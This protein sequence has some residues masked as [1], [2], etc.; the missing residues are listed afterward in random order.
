MRRRVPRSIA[1]AAGAAIVLVA[2]GGCGKSAS[3]THAQAPRPA[4]TV[5]VATVR[6]LAPDDYRWALAHGAR[7]VR[8]PATGSFS[9]VSRSPRRPTALVVAVHGHS[10]NAFT[11]YRLWQPYAARR[12]LALVAVEWQ[13][14]WGSGALFLDTR[15]TYGMIDRA[16]RRAHVAPGRVL[17]HGF[18]KGS[19]ASFGL[20]SLDRAADRL[21]AL[22]I[23]ESGGAHAA[24]ARDPRLPGTHWVL[25]CGARDQWPYISG[26]PAMRAARTYLVL[27]GALI[28]RFIV[29]RPARHGG[30]LLNGAAVAAALDDFG[31]VLA[32]R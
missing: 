29:D 13:L 12:R 16:V 10:G 21:F 20:T 3:A 25:Y 24:P 8:D 2:A 7:I 14:R 28:D 27:N 1:A 9:V 18:S 22:T 23:A 17:L 31:R 32:R 19:H 6:A 15:G 11:Q 30:F 5:S 26:C 4:V